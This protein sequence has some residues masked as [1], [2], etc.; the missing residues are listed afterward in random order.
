MIN[1]TVETVLNKFKSANQD[2]IMAAIEMQDIDFLDST[3]DETKKNIGDLCI[4]IKMLENF[5][6][7]AT[8][9]S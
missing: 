5:L 9:D 7:E 1:L 6:L 3:I 2:L 4:V 8:N